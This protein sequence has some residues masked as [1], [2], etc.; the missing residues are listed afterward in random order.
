MYVLSKCLIEPAFTSKI[1][2]DYKKLKF[3]NFCSWKRVEFVNCE[4]KSTPNAPM[5]FGVEAQ[6]FETWLRQ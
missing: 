1:Y 4:N 6:F 2:N 3:P 5:A